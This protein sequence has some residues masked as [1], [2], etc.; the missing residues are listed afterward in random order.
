MLINEGFPKQ[1]TVGVGP[2]LDVTSPDITC[3][4]EATPPALIAE[5][6]AG[7]KIK[8]QWY[9][10]VI[11][12]LSKILT[13]HRSNYFTSHKG[14]V[15]TYM[16]RWNKGESPQDVKFFKIDEA[17]YNPKNG[18][19][20]SDELI[21]ANNTH[22]V[23]I[24]SDIKPGTYMVRH[25]L[26]ALHFGFSGNA[27][28]AGTSASGAQFLPICLNVKVI[29]SGTAEPEGV[30]FPGGYK[31]SDKGILANIYY[32]PNSYTSPGPPLYKGKYEDPVGPIPK[33]Q[34]TGATINPMY[35]SAVKAADTV[36]YSIVKGV[37]QALPGG[38]GYH[39][40]VGQGAYN[41]PVN[42]GQSL[43][44]VGNL[45]KG[46]LLPTGVV[47]GVG[48]TGSTEKCQPNC[49]DMPKRPQVKEGKQA[50][51]KP[52]T[53]QQFVPAIGFNEEDLVSGFDL[54]QVIY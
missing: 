6:R 26:V 31:P 36:L 39:Y 53:K 29:G 47:P 54:L 5:A 19:W 4:K 45:Y 33:V 23:Q 21:D 52:E 34:F 22:T 44:P 40:D 3:R 11:P 28:G 1:N 8:F 27:K 13:S 50:R 46:G 30:T 25:E 20:G 32:G 49:A 7:S 12:M 41:A 51:P 2:V 10:F 37:N 17:T 38:G 43:A 16:G 14:P 42:G 18:K 35:D 48:Y 24:P 15:L 9:S